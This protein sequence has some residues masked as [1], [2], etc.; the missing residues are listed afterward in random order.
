MVSNFRDHIKQRLKRRDFIRTLI[1]HLNGHSLSFDFSPLN[2]NSMIIILHRSSDLHSTSLDYATK[3][4]RPSLGPR[5]DKDESYR[6]PTQGEESQG[7]IDEATF[8]YWGKTRPSSPSVSRLPRWS[9]QPQELS[10]TD[11]RDGSLK[12][13]V[14]SLG[15]TEHRWRSMF[16]TDPPHS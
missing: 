2:L 11:L 3:V 10:R 13:D 8:K 6:N 14:S 16:H 1:L 5:K 7:A 15:L 12:G 9:T 4:R